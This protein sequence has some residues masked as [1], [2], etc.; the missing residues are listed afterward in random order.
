MG[1]EGRNREKKVNKADVER[2]LRAAISTLLRKDS[3]LI[4]HDVNERAIT[5]KLG[6]YLQREFPD[7]HVDCEYNRVGTEDAKKVVRGL[8][9]CGGNVPTDD[10]SGRTVYPDI[11]VHTRGKTGSGSNL[12]VVE[13]KKASNPNRTGC[14][15][16]KLDA[17]RN[18]LHYRFAVAVTV[19]GPSSRKPYELTWRKA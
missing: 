8:N 12:L 19:L 10:T 1:Q 9:S 7:W 17:Y 5:H 11:I 15:L 6:E 18:Q 2:G 4:E 16:E 14:D 3:F 13:L